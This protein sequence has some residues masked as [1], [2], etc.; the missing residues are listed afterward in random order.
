[1]EEAQVAR[2]NTEQEFAQTAN[3][4]IDDLTADLQ[5]KMTEL[6]DLQ[7]S[8]LQSP[9]DQRK[10]MKLQIEVLDEEIAGLHA[11]SQGK[12][13][14]E[15][16]VEELSKQL[17]GSKHRTAHAEKLGK[18]AVDA[19]EEQNDKFKIRIEQSKSKGVAA[20]SQVKLLEE[21]NEELQIQLIK[22]PDEKLGFGYRVIVTSTKVRASTLQRMHVLCE[23]DLRFSDLYREYEH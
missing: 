16:Q 15:L 14:L 8:M 13:G 9:K 11:D 22:S 12:S 17:D 21:Q 10:T 1:M 5:A 20:K 18:E 6:Y 7:N 3:R 23:F 19:L 4:Q 2:E